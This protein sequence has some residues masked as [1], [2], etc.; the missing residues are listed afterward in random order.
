LNK[1]LKFQITGSFNFIW[2]L[3]YIITFYNILIK[4]YI[5][6]FLF[7]NANINIIKKYIY[8]LKHLKKEIIYTIMN[9]YNVFY[10]LVFT[11]N[12]Y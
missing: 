2:T 7:K 4:T 1:I 3:V 8:N 6:L 12:K 11:I 5:S 10:F 9:T